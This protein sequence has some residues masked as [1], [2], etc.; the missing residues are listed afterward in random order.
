MLGGYFVFRLILSFYSDQLRSTA[1]SVPMKSVMDVFLSSAEATL[2]FRSV[3]QLNPWL[4]GDN[5][6]GRLNT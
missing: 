4:G 6:F 5:R 2:G 1:G 3:C